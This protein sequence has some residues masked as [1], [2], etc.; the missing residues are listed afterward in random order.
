M[1]P[2]VSSEGDAFVGSRRSIKRYLICTLGGYFPVLNKTPGGS[3]AVVFRVGDWHIGINGTLALSTSRDGG[4]SW[5]GP[6]EITPRGR[7]DRNPAFGVLKNGDMVLT[8]WR[9]M[10]PEKYPTPDTVWDIFATRSG[11]QG[12]TWCKPVRIPDRRCW[13]PY[14]RIVECDDGTLLLSGYT[15]QRKRTRGVLSLLRSRDGGVTWGDESRVAADFNEASFLVMPDGKTILA[16]ARH[17][18]PESCLAVMRS[19]NGGRTWTKPRKITRHNEHPADLTLLKSGRVMTTFGRR[20]T[21]TGVGV[22]FSDDGGRTWNRDKEVLLTGHGG[23]YQDLGYPSTVQLDDETI[24]TV[25]YDATT[26]PMRPGEEH[27]RNCAFA[28]RYREKDI[29]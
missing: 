22:L 8:F 2:I 28:M 18:A 12:K 19:R 26:L 11:D 15:W 7:D 16:A 23:R 5:S 13:S 27:W 24:V 1:P 14:G 20:V 10:T 17:V 9:C 6:S 21:P 3:L 4:R 29:T 25:A